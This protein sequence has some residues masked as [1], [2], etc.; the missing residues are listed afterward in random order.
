MG[1]LLL[2]L[3][4]CPIPE[5]IT[6][7]HKLQYF[8]DNPRTEEEVQAVKDLLV[9]LHAKYPS[10]VPLESNEP[11]VTI[12]NTI[13]Q[14]YAAFSKDNE[15]IKSFYDQNKEI[16]VFE[17]V[18]RMWI[19]VRFEEAVEHE[20]L[21]GEIAGFT[22]DGEVM[23][24]IAEQA[25]IRVDIPEDIIKYGHLVSLLLR[26]EE[27]IHNIESFIINP[28]APNVEQ[29]M[30]KIWFHFAE[31][32]QI[33]FEYA[34]Y[35]FEPWYEWRFFPF[36][37]EELVQ[38]GQEIDA[39]FEIESPEKLLYIGN[40][41]RVIGEDLHDTRFKLV[42]LTSILELLLTRNPDTGRFNVE[43]SINK[44]FQLKA[45]ILVYLHDKTQD[46]NEIKKILRLIYQQ[47]S[48]IAHGNF[49][50]VS[51]YI[52]K[53]PQGESF[54]ELVI[55]LHSYVQAV[56]KEYISDPNFVNFMKE[57]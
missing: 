49:R 18:A 35:E 57:G 3:Y 19:V 38:M 56:L 39:I 5:R 37:V 4:I 51:K 31:F 55:Y 23:F 41:L 13:S 36:V 14:F 48:N 9:K 52:N 15:Y 10:V 7:S 12:T 30:S 2:T 29:R 32:G 1:L 43:D 24:E 28:T 8:L 50:E 42:L 33:C 45:A 34:K 54:E 21:S 25:T 47:R 16:D 6:L 44:Q 46:I 26:E 53:N 40:V 27:Q 17:F 22:Q 11:I 20:V